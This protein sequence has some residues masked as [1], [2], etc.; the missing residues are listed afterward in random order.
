MEE[1]RS[2][3][4]GNRCRRTAAAARKGKSAATV[5]RAGSRSV[6]TGSLR[7]IRSGEPAV[8]V[9]VLQSADKS[10]VLLYFL[11][12]QAEFL[13]LYALKSVQ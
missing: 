4:E 9:P 6:R 8:G 7:S 11:A 10:S 3:Q 13:L 1:N 2:G 5:T 12:M